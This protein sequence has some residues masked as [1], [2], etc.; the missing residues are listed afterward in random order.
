MKL[1]LSVDLELDI[2]LLSFKRLFELGLDFIE[3][4]LEFVKCLL[5]IHDSL[6]ILLQAVCQVRKV[7]HLLLGLDLLHLLEYG[8]VLLLERVL[9]DSQLLLAEYE[10]LV[11]LLNFVDQI[12]HQCL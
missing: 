5:F 6:V 11:L 7:L 4:L 10:G 12:R 2:I 1:V 8:R 3:A 9:V